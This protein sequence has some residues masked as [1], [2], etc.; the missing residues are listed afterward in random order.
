MLVF[1]LVSGRYVIK[2]LVMVMECPVKVLEFHGHRRLAD[3][4][5]YVYD[6]SILVTGGTR[7]DIQPELIQCSNACRWSSDGD[8]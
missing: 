8:V 4:R 5:H 1:E 2:I 3:L 7:K 6:V